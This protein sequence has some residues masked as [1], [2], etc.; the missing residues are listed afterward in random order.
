MYCPVGISEPR[1]CP[2]G[3]LRNE[4]GAT[5]EHD[6]TPCP[7]GR[8]C[9]TKALSEPTGPCAAG[10]LCLERATHL[11]PRDGLTE[12]ATAVRACSTGHFNPYEGGTS[13][14]DCR[15]CFPGYYCTVD[16]NDP[17]TPIVEKCRAGYY[18]PEGSSSP[19][20]SIAPAG[21]FAPEGSATAEA[22]RPGTW[23]AKAGAA[24]CDLCP[25]GYYCDEAGLH[26]DHPPKDC[27]KGMY[28][29]EGSVF[30]TNCP[31][32]TYNPEQNG[33]SI[34]DC[35]MCPAGKYC[36]TEELE[37]PSGDCAAGYYC[38]SRS[39]SIAPLERLKQ[40]P[41]VKSAH[42]D[43][44]APWAQAT[45]SLVSREHTKIWKAVPT[46]I[47]AVPAIIV[48]RE[49][50]LHL[51]TSTSA[52]QGRSAQQERK[53]KRSTSVLQTA[54]IVRL[55]LVTKKKSIQVGAD[56]VATCGTVEAPEEEQQSVFFRKLCIEAGL[57]TIDP[58]N[59]ENA[60][61]PGYYCPEGSPTKVPCPAG[62]YLPASGAWEEQQCQSCPLGQ[63]CAFPGLASPSGY[64]SAGFFCEEGSAAPVDPTK[65][66]A[67]GHYCPEGTHTAIP[68]ESGTYQPQK[69]ATICLTCPQGSYCEPGSTAP[70][71]C[72]A[73]FFCP[74][75]TQHKFQFP[76]PQG[77]YGVAQG[78]ISS[79]SCHLCLG[80]QLCSTPGTSAQGDLAM[81]PCPAGYYCANGTGSV[82]PT[83]CT[84]GEY[85]P[86]N[87]TLPTPCP[88]GYYCA[89]EALEWPT[90]RCRGG[91]IC[92][93]RSSTHSPEAA[94]SGEM[95][96]EKYQGYPCPAGY[97]CH[98]APLVD[99][100]KGN[101]NTKAAGDGLSAPE[102]TF[103]Q[104]TGIAVNHIRGELIVAEYQEGRISS[105]HLSTGLVTKIKTGLKKP[106]GLAVS[107]DGNILYASLS[108]DGKV[109]AIS[110]EDSGVT[111]VQTGLSEPWGL[112]L[113][114][115]GET[116]Y[117]AQ[118]GANKI[119]AIKLSNKSLT[120]VIGSGA[121]ANITLNSPYA[122]AV[123]LDEKLY[124][125]DTGNRRIILADGEN[126][127]IIQIQ[128]PRI[129]T[130]KE[131][132]IDYNL[133]YIVALTFGSLQSSTLFLADATKH[134]V[135]RLDLDTHRIEQVLGTG[136]EGFSGDG[137]IIPAPEAQ[138]NTPTG[139]AVGEKHGAPTKTLYVLDSGNQRVRK[140]F[141][142][143]SDRGESTA[144]LPCPE[145]TFSDSEGAS[146]SDDC[147]PC[148]AGYACQGVGQPQVTS[149]CSE[150]YYCPEG[151]LFNVAHNAIVDTL[152]SG[153]FVGGNTPE[154]VTDGDTDLGTGWISQSTEN[155][156][157][158][159]I[160]DL[161][162]LFFIS[163]IR[164]IS[165]GQTESKYF[166]SSSSSYLDL[167]SVA[168][169]EHSDYSMSFGEV[170]TTKIMLVSPDAQVF[171]SEI[172]VFGT[173]APGPASPTPCPPGWYQDLKAQTECK[174]CPA[175]NYCTDTSATPSLKCPQ[176]YYCLK[177]SF[178]GYEYPCPL[179]TYNNQVGAKSSS[180]CLP[181]PPGK[182]CGS[183]GLTEPTG[184]CL[185]G[186]YCQGGAW[187]PAPHA[188]ES[189]PDGIAGSSGSLCPKGYY[190]TSGA[191]TPTQCPEGTSSEVPGGKQ[192]S[193][194]LA[195][196][197]GNYCSN[198]MGT[199]LCAEG[200]YCTEGSTTPTP[201]EDQHGGRCP[202]G[203][204]C[205]EGSYVSQVDLYVTM[206]DSLAHQQFAPAD[207]FAP[208]VPK[209]TCYPSMYLEKSMR[210]T[211]CV[212]LGT[213]A[214]PAL[215]R[216]RPVIQER[217]RFL[218]G[219]GNSLPN[220]DYSKFPRDPYIPEDVKEAGTGVVL[221]ET[222]WE[223]MLDNAYGG[224]PCPPGY[225]C[226][227][228]ATEPSNCNRGSFRLEK[229]GR[230]PSDCSLCP[231]GYY[232]TPTVAIPTPCPKGHYCSRGSQTPTA[233][234]E[235]YYNA[236]EGQS[237]SSSCLLCPAGMTCPQEGTSELTDENLCPEG[238][239][240]IQGS[241]KALPCAAGYHNP[242]M[243][244][245]SSS[246]CR[247][248]PGGIF[249]GKPGTADLSVP[250]PEGYY[251]PAK[252]P[253]AL[254]C[255]P[256]TYC[257]AG[258]AVPST[259]PGGSFCP[260]MSSVP[261]TCPQ[262]FYCPSGAT[263]PY[264][265]PA[266][267]RMNPYDILRSSASTACV[268][269]EEGTY[270][271]TDGSRDC[272]PCQ[273][274]YI[275]KYIYTFNFECSHC[276]PYSE[277]T[278]FSHEDS[279]EP[280]LPKEYPECGGG[281]IRTHTG[282]CQSTNQFCQN[283][284]GPKGG[285][286]IPKSGLCSCNFLPAVTDVCDENCR[287]QQQTFSTD[288]KALLVK[289]G[290]G[291]IRTSFSIGALKGRSAV[292]FGP[293][294][295][296][297]DSCPVIFLAAAQDGTTRG[298]FG[299]PEELL[300]AMSERLS[301][302]V[303]ER[304]TVIS[305][306]TSKLR[307]PAQNVAK[308]VQ[309]TN[310]VPF[311][312]SPL[313]CTLV[314]SSILW[315]LSPGSEPVY[316]VHINDSLLN[317]NPIF[318]DGEFKKLQIEMES[319]APFLLFG[320]TFTAPGVSVF[321]TNRGTN[322]ITIINVVEQ[323][324]QCGPM[325][326]NLPHTATHESI[327][328]LPLKLPA[329]VL[330]GPPDWNTIYV[331]FLILLVLVLAILLAQYQVRLKY[332]TFANPQEIEHGDH[333][334]ES[335]Q[336]IHPKSLH[337]AILWCKS[338]KHAE[339]ESTITF[340]DLD[341][342]AF[343]AVYC[344]LL[345]TMGTLGSKLQLLGAHQDTLIELELDM[346][347]P[348][349]SALL[350][351]LTEASEKK[352][353]AEVEN[354][355]L[356]EKLVSL[357]NAMLLRKGTL[358]EA[359]R[360][361]C[362][363]MKEAEMERMKPLTQIQR[364]DGL[365]SLTLNVHLGSRSAEPNAHDTSPRFHEIADVTAESFAAALGVEQSAATTQ[366]L[367]HLKAV[368]AAKQVP[369]KLEVQLTGVLYH[370][371]GDL[372][373]Y[374]NSLQETLKATLASTR[375]EL[376]ERRRFIENAL[377]TL[378][379]KS[380]AIAAHEEFA[381]KEKA[382]E[383]EVE[384]MLRQ[385][386]TV[387]K[388][389]VEDLVAQCRKSVEEGK[390]DLANVEQ[391]IYFQCEAAQAA[392]QTAYHS[393]LAQINQEQLA[394]RYELERRLMV[395]RA[396][397][398]CLSRSYLA[399]DSADELS[400]E[401]QAET[402][403][404]LKRVTLEQQT[405]QAD[406]KATLNKSCALCLQ[407]TGK[408]FSIA[409]AIAQAEHNS[410]VLSY[411][412]KLK[413]VSSELTCLLNAQTKLE[414]TRH[415]HLRRFRARIMIE[416]EDYLAKL[417]I[418]LETSDPVTVAIE[419]QQCLDVLNRNTRA[420]YGTL[421]HAL[422]L[423]HDEAYIKAIEEVRNCRTSLLRSAELEE[424]EFTRIIDF[425][426]AQQQQVL[427][428][429]EE[430]QGSFS[431][432]ISVQNLEV[433][434]GINAAHDNLFIERIRHQFIEDERDRLVSQIAYAKAEPSWLWTEAELANAIESLN[435]ESSRQVQDMDALMLEQ[436]K[437]REAEHAKRCEHRK[438][439]LLNRISV[440]QQAR[441]QCVLWTERQYIAK[442]N[443]VN[444]Q[445]SE[446]HLLTCQ[447]SDQQFFVLLNKLRQKWSDEVSTIDF[448]D[449]LTAKRSKE[450]ENA[451]CY[452]L[453]RLS[454]VIAPPL[455]PIHERQ[456]LLE[457]S[458]AQWAEFVHALV[459]T[460]SKQLEDSLLQTS[461]R[462][463]KLQLADE[464]FRGSFP[465]EWEAE[466][467][468]ATL[469]QR[470]VMKLFLGA[471]SS[472]EPRWHTREYY[473]STEETN[474]DRIHELKQKQAEELS[475]IQYKIN[476]SLKPTT[477]LHIVEAEKERS[478][479]THPLRDKLL[480]LRKQAEN[481]CEDIEA[482]NTIEKEADPIEKQITL[483]EDASKL[484]VKAATDDR[485]QRILS[486]CTERIEQELQNQRL[487]LET[488]WKLLLS[489]HKA[490]LE[491]L[492]Q[493]H[494]LH[495]VLLTEYIR[496]EA[497]QKTEDKLHFGKE[498]RTDELAA[499]A[500]Q[501]MSEDARVMIDGGREIEHLKERHQSELAQ[502][503]REEKDRQRLV[504]KRKAGKRT[505][506]RQGKGTCGIRNSPAAG[507]K[508][509]KS[510]KKLAKL[511]IGYPQS[512]PQKENQAKAWKMGRKEL[513]DMSHPIIWKIVEEEADNGSYEL[514]ERSTSITARGPTLS[515]IECIIE[516]LAEGSFLRTT[517]ANL[518]LLAQACSS[519]QAAS[520]N[521]SL[522]SRGTEEAASSYNSD[523]KSTANS[524]QDFA[525]LQQSSASSR[526]DTSHREGTSSQKSSTEETSN[527][528][529]SS[530]DETDSSEEYVS[531]TASQTSSETIVTS[532]R[533]SSN[534]STLHAQSF[535]S[536]SSSGSYS[537]PPKLI[538]GSKPMAKNCSLLD[539][540]TSGER[541]AESTSESGEEVSM[542]NNRAIRESM[543]GTSASKS[544]GSSSSSS[545]RTSEGTRGQSR[546]EDIRSRGNHNMVTTLNNG[547]TPI[548]GSF[549]QHHSSRQSSSG[550]TSS[551]S[552]TNSSNDCS[553]SSSSA[554]C[555]PVDQASVQLETQQN[556]IRHSNSNSS[557]SAESCSISSSSGIPNGGTNSRSTL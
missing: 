230:W 510:R 108:E 76:C 406:L 217:I 530:S 534:P 338:K 527:T 322:R 83:A 315:Q 507:I 229:G 298:Y 130:M 513:L 3:T 212:P 542:S 469:H 546:R 243:G 56:V 107:N 421:A 446:M 454:P 432:K 78:A 323:V 223:A 397:N 135:W 237:S 77:T 238:H 488:Q 434:T 127:E 173:S 159:L 307:R 9:A 163:E 211:D 393:A 300:E 347:G 288:G 143:P 521:L 25:A 478:L 486:H 284:C 271:D 316:P 95:C 495:H 1:P 90:G 160:I 133:G 19:T 209:A 476:V 498:S 185:A 492:Q 292:L 162:K 208:A 94:T 200:Y 377:G 350:P 505:E 448:A 250:C 69:G 313:L 172:M 287:E 382:A 515:S 439:L 285:S 165:G 264:A 186:Y 205:P 34:D 388:H 170:A 358:E 522:Q 233:C 84:Y 219:L 116:L 403:P 407:L 31:P 456:A 128:P 35:R 408:R 93:Q 193:D 487:L 319:G 192:A 214:L 541:V 417:K 248:C 125:A 102:A 355:E 55:V 66:C 351:V 404:Q 263:A 457:S 231:A 337:E 352:E 503:Q 331:T 361:A 30:H 225:Y 215:R 459:N 91:Y 365:T 276:H 310:Q 48:P 484:Q 183:R 293:P 136:S 98:T 267:S 216:P 82:T 491:D 380:N 547:L 187:S 312:E 517:L 481:A 339:G 141:I 85:C 329:A 241:S 311:I 359:V 304:S 58:S 335:L 171:I 326:V 201:S 277:G 222:N 33:K 88:S 190:C 394:Y 131:T 176:G 174:V 423:A 536:R 251:C 64:C 543:S 291:S 81:T 518:K 333:S 512:S 175:G 453:A 42:K 427:N 26:L 461:T 279:E 224:I 273:P 137:R 43:T 362:E 425:L 462:R 52:Q 529:T 551:F 500:R 194:C 294:S 181:C 106:G 383:Q 345:E 398:D 23:S 477:R 340:P 57:C 119:S 381:E 256:G 280:C 188:E 103:S 387:I 422:T 343:Q 53:V 485:R 246:D 259:C 92:K 306:D 156:E 302:S 370:T 104:L 232:C 164:I 332:W 336:Q 40:S 177:G 545:S 430:W 548:Q 68:C 389:S 114:L 357:K 5:S 437:F 552:A 533:K 257:P 247:P 321:A 14:E 482:L 220:P 113:S 550:T 458:I 146:T 415:Q 414:K 221:T 438:Q 466:W 320:Y 464:T 260:L 445:H 80:G 269:C 60:C 124:V 65:L 531:R 110:L 120:D 266:G 240:C 346:G 54:S 360:R 451:F 305:M 262:G 63:Y 341:P 155:L 111:D 391:S 226:T 4:T 502:A 327:A 516:S 73:G 79:A 449:N 87:S 514:Y 384:A 301:L 154:H 349:K 6:C 435:A 258:S 364:N 59:A 38:A 197:P 275:C 463:E 511:S 72:P 431:T 51:M 419:L 184:D 166:H 150:G 10:T 71:T 371:P 16:P 553:S 44:G 227:E 472:R 303:A 386:T 465:Q 117:V 289:S 504:M 416:I 144:E 450:Q 412:L 309:A 436:S 555:S 493:L 167:F 523:G 157:H 99:T 140:V 21:S 501:Q 283:F 39:T 317:T 401:C 402:D 109:I 182:Y 390:Q 369:G 195:C 204:Y 261:E 489:F 447:I 318:D 356:S 396:R 86:E 556:R 138:I 234:P 100:L 470:A 139:V 373:A 506:R 236:R 549:S 497:Q 395:E 290:N 342:R 328:T 118:A 282:Q 480:A 196:L 374:E 539:R 344:K 544:S 490:E 314:G 330:Y 379:D 147:I 499:V 460:W 151:A 479:N 129:R 178:S 532:I 207:L 47:L 152:T 148:P 455:V 20:A 353:M 203:H 286:Y 468:A 405:A 528:E 168:S 142:S 429:Y 7:A 334:K 75:G 444:R 17:T 134:I 235:R 372:P 36:Q 74:A 509:L 180:E 496:R 210:T 557:E 494:N 368:E 89:N 255:P 126:V 420:T 274:G 348:L 11:A 161:G 2:V 433:A 254:P 37:Q 244:S 520:S 242:Q 41:L 525:V 278:D 228:G 29:P 413:I 24:S 540:L 428:E 123:A 179:G 272:T 49:P 411:D 249:C 112:S 354:A 96:P 519:M 265:C 308:F 443:A 426:R 452:M 50:K 61:P 97:Y 218:C 105:I 524:S 121:P 366:A 67:E 27:R 475:A 132:A 153:D 198:S 410:A 324:T 199:G 409:K 202:A 376:C 296:D 145:G 471:T 442:R 363:A 15:P 45:Q 378:V 537:A 440:E 32:G 18:C 245:L 149:R 13:E 239:Y 206:P 367:H 508:A 268:A 213:T 46:A 424:E 299:V 189:N 473:E 392:N 158:G 554:S 467:M 385:R 399:S 474:S 400:E 22:C 12:G 191:T 270:S 325:T 483:L 253:V 526:S 375:S 28:C 297:E 538:A 122:V 295:C 115:D 441:K 252:T 169:N 70:K 101:G 418:L 535:E 281:A 62:K 8:Y